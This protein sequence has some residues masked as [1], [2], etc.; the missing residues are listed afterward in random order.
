MPTLVQG[1]EDLTLT[2]PEPHV[3][4]GC[5]YGK[6]SQEPF[7]DSHTQKE[8]MELVHSDIIGPIR[9]PSINKS[10]YIL[11]FI[12]HRSRYPK[13]YFTKTKDASTILGHF[14]EYKAWAENITERKIKILRTDGGGEYLN[15]EMRAY[16]KEHGIE[17][18]HTVPYTPQQNGI[19][20]RFNRTLIERT[21]AIL[22]SQKLPAKLWAE[23]LDTVCYLYTLGPI[24]AIKNST[25]LMV[26][27]NPKDKPNV[28]HLRIIGCT[29]YVHINKQLRTKLD[30]KSIKCILVGYGNDSKAYRV[31]NPK[32]DKIFYSRDVV[33]DETQVGVQDTIIEDTSLLDI[34][35]TYPIDD[36]EYDI[37][38]IEQERSSNG[39]REYYVKWKGYN[40]SENTWEPYHH[41]IDT[42]A[43]DEWEKRNPVRKTIAYTAEVDNSYLQ[44]DPQNLQDALS[45]P[46]KDLWIDAM[47]DEIRSLQENDT[48]E[49]IKCPIDRDVIGTRWVFHIKKHIDGSIEKRKGRFVAKGYTQ[50][51]GIDFNE[52]YAP[53]VSHT[54]IRLLIALATQYN[55]IIHQMDVKSA[56]L[57]GNIDMELYIEQPEMFEERDSKNWVYRLKKGL[58]G[59]KQAGRIWH[60]TL[61]NHLIPYGYK[62]LESEPSIYIKRNTD[63]NIIIIAVYVDDLQILC[64]DMKMLENAKEGLKTQFK[65]T[66]LGEVHH[67]LG[68]RIL[69]SENKTS[70]DQA[71]Y[72]ESVLKRTNMYD[73]TP[74]K[75]PMETHTLLMPLPPDKEGHNIEEY[76]SI[77]GALN[78]AAVLTRP[79]I[80]TTVG[81]L[82]RHMQKPR[83]SHWNALRRVL[84]YL[85][86]TM[87]YGLVYH[88]TTQNGTDHIQV[89]CDSDWA[90]DHKDRKS[91]TGYIIM[92]NRTAISHKSSKQS[93]VSTSSVEAEYI[94]L[95][96]T[97]TEVLW[98]CTLLQELGFNGSTATT[99]IIDSDG[100]VNIPENGIVSHRTRHI[101]V[102]HHFIKHNIES[103]IIALRHCSSA[104]N[105][106]DTF[107]KAL[108]YQRFAECR[109]EMG[110]EEILT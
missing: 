100:A 53:V 6:Q 87:N 80:S 16:L 60:K 104:S 59:L 74:M 82:V 85:K 18:Q 10:R 96:T 25:P 35:D 101:D 105:T 28:D 7:K 15:V 43:L 36:H 38:Q 99:I 42:R 95:A 52:T 22:H 5:M 14:K 4:E 56:F 70:I 78:Y 94:A 37:E 84:R 21:R 109:A 54:A 30:A 13:C 88:S 102:K 62:S 66:D 46:D 23:V 57:H 11:T 71:H 73:C 19:A 2:P 45:R 67:I 92:F 75:T 34:D 51:P 63:D 31:W 108:P 55:L 107:T 81:F 89:Y 91:T 65:M 41:L 93:G 72:I 86:G 61:H 44:T 17:H 27:Q 26:F 68:L 8:L 90:R 48:W 1:M 49:L 50:I 83:I 3:C 69:R 98:I 79:D 39:Q 110:M 64:N 106:A 58:Y 97:A 32:T 47:T 24:R 76:R 40:S 33:F 77:I 9:I 20:E 29:A 12:E 103:N